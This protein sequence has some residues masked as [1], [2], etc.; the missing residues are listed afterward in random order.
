LQRIK[1]ELFL[2]QCSCQELPA[3]DIC[4]MEI[5][6][7]AV[8]EPAAW[9]VLLIYSIYIAKTCTD[10]LKKEY[11]LEENYRDV[12]GMKINLFV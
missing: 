1:H 12:G 9:A 10:S 6:Q 2:G 4:H 11:P 8:L 5:N 7:Y 3:T